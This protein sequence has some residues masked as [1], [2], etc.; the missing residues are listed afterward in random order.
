MKNIMLFMADEMDLCDFS[1]VL[2]ASQI[3][4]N[5]LIVL[6]VVIPLIMIIMGSISFA[7]AVTA[8]KIDYKKPLQELMVRVAGAL[9]IFLTPSI[10]HLIFGLVTEFDE[11]RT[12]LVNCEVC[13]YNPGDNDCSSKIIAAEE[14]EK[15][16]EQS[17]SYSPN[18]PV[19][20][21]P[22][23]NPGPGGSQG[24]NE[25]YTTSSPGTTYTYEWVS[26]PGYIDYAMLTPSTA[27]TGQ[28]TALIIWLH[29]SDE[30]GISS[31]SFKNRGPFPTL[32]NWNLD[33]YNAYFVAPRLGGNYNTYYWDS[34]E[35]LGYIDNLISK[36]KSEKNI[37]SKRIYIAGHSLG[38]MG[39]LYAAEKRANTFAAALVM[40]GYPYGQPGN[41]GNVN[42]ITIPTKGYV[43]STNYGEQGA[44]Y[45]YMSQ[46]FK[47]K[48]GD[49]N[50]TVY[51]CG[52]GSVPKYA[53]SQDDNGDNKSD[54]LE[55]LL[56]QKKS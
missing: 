6:K 26:T 2:R 54:V 22:I 11:S 23:P 20:P 46:T 12:S 44:S 50:L 3:M 53:F 28:K 1:A 13:L 10:I 34:E 17:G 24:G 52:H 7:K 33:G 56:S 18:I 15:N 8:S 45:N 14:M 40:S 37:D 51:N 39:A 55:W 9:L 19:N 48:M 16:N 31:E 29:G 30:R 5:V 42:N 36:L 4:G 38:G 47:N 41:T 21:N 25:T 43:G 35:A 32:L 27:S 49:S